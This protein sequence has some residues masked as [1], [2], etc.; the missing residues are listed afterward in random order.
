M[1]EWKSEYAVN[2]GTIDAQHQTLFAM[3][4]ELHAAMSAG[5]GKSVLARLLNRLVHYTETHFAHEER[6][7]QLHGYPGF[8]QHKS[9]HEALTRRVLAFETDFNA[10][11]TDMAVEV[12]QFLSDWL[13]KHIQGSDLAYAPYLKARKVA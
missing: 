3:C 6:L 12:L 10:G 8:A 2:I 1:F 7:M 5:Q 13:G 11:R 9:E 4:G